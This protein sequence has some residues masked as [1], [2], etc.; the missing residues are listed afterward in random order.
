MK[1]FSDLIAYLD[2]NVVVVTRC[3][4]ICLSIQKWALASGFD[5]T[6]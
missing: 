5:L 1:S 3:L 6:S 4:L 2:Q